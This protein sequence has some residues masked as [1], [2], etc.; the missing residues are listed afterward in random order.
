[1]YKDLK[2]PTKTKKTEFNRVAGY[3]IN[4]QR[5]VPF[6]YINNELSE[7]EIKKQSHL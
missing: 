6:L 1:M 5:S 4:I 3:K 2:T 7:M